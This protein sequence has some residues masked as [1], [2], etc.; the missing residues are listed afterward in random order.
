ML[1][2][3][4][5]KKRELRAMEGHVSMR[6]TRRNLKA[7]S[8]VGVKKIDRR[9]DESNN[10]SKRRNIKT[11]KIKIFK[12]RNIKTWKK[13]GNNTDFNN[14]KYYQ[15]H[16]YCNIWGLNSKLYKTSHFKQMSIW[17]IHPGPEWQLPFTLVLICIAFWGNLVWLVSKPIQFF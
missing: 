12:I 16:K 8:W 15:G 1:R 2:K 5:H 9:C 14:F 3:W 17:C 13:F 10:S 6:Y 4:H 11:F 7:M